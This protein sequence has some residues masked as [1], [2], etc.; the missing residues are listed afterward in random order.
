MVK[1]IA[2]LSSKPTYYII[3]SLSGTDSM[4]KFYL[5]NHDDQLRENKTYEI[6]KEN[7]HIRFLNSYAFDEIQKPIKN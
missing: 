6:G 3:Q 2:E 1:F 7:L 5:Q 4:L